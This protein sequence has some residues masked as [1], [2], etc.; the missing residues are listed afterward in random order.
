MPIV[1]PE[2]GLATSRPE[3]A[4]G[5]Q[6][7]HA[8]FACAR[9]K[10]RRPGVLLIHESFGVTAHMEDV[11]R[12]FALAGFATLAPNL[13]VDFPAPP[14]GDAPTVI[15]AL[16]QFDDKKALERLSVASEWLKH[17]GRCNGNVGAVGFSM[18]GKLALLLAFTTN[19]L[20]AVVPFYGSIVPRTFPGMPPPAAGVQKIS[21]IDVAE[22]LACPLQ[23]HYAGKD[24]S[25]PRED[26]DAL[27]KKLGP[28]GRTAD[29]YFYPDASHAFHNDHRPEVYLEASAKQAF[30]RTLEFLKKHLG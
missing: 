2:E 20:S 29:F 18:G 6:E 16:N 10:D 13:F 14:M 11:T 21:P 3:I 4:V 19:K 30:Q 7:M 24:A 8:Y 9:G 1:T 25:I 22:G 17:H 28:S 26:V 27:E 5:D 15:R 23:G 12:R